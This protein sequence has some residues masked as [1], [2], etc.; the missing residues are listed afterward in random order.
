MRILVNTTFPAFN[1]DINNYQDW[2]MDYAIE[3]A[4]MMGLQTR[5]E[6]ILHEVAGV[7]AKTRP[8]VLPML[9]SMYEERLWNPMYSCVLPSVSISQAAVTYSRTDWISSG[10]NRRGQIFEDT[11]TIPV[12]CHPC[13]ETYKRWGWVMIEDFYRALRALREAYDIEWKDI[14]EV[15]VDGNWRMPKYRYISKGPIAELITHI[16]P[17]DRYGEEITTRTTN[18]VILAEFALPNTPEAERNSANC[19]VIEEEVE[20]TV[21]KK[22]R[23]ISCV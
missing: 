9:W 4:T 1:S 22:V 10:S 20:Q 12:N 15:E 14:S 17:T 18:M 13:W 19:H 6:P 11:V 7:V 8:T 23:R 16:E 3:A 5:I 21:I 2:S